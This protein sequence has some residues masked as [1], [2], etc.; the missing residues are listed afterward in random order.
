MVFR[1]YAHYCGT[2]LLGPYPFHE[3]IEE[4]RNVLYVEEIVL[5]ENVAIARSRTCG[6]TLKY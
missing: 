5:H 3:D 6:E 1:E 4:D 2:V